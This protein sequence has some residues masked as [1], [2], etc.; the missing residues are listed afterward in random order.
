M[1]NIYTIFLLM[2][3]E[4]SFIPFPSEIVMIPTG[5][6]VY[7]DRINIIPAIISA[8]LGSLCGALINY[9]IATWFGRKYLMSSR[10][11]S[12]SKLVIAEKFCAKYGFLAVFL[13]RL[14]P[15]I[16]QYISLPC[17][18][19][20]MNLLQF[21]ISTILGSAIWC[22][23]LIFVGYMHGYGKTYGKTASLLGKCSLVFFVLLIIYIIFSHYKISKKS[24][25]L[26]SPE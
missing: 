26:S 17:G 16:R 23:I 11:I 22:G 15:I 9:F 6:L 18:F 7:N 10:F 12:S 25:D 1:L 19:I 20:K 21:C 8:I 3:I 5:Y 4:S 14:V 13:S 24:D 2:T